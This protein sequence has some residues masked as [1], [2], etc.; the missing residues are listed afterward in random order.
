MGELGS[1]QLDVVNRA[2]G[3]PPSRVIAMGG[4]DY[5]R[6]GREVYD[7]V[8]CTYEY[9]APNAGEGKPQTVHVA[10]SSIQTNAHEGMSELIMGTKGTLLLS[11][12]LGLFYSEVVPAALA[13]DGLSG[14]TLAVPNSPWAHRGK[15]MEITSAADDTR[16]ELLSFV[17]AVRASNR[18]TICDVR[19]GLE[20]TATIIIANEAIRSGSVVTFPND[21]RADAHA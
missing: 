4:V 11:Q 15:P 21:C 2:L 1:H 8:F 9:N 18:K 12:K 17:Q 5:W 3:V 7:N 16:A 10:F 6:D 19:V 13:V 14:A 20:N